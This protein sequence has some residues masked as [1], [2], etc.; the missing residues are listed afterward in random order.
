MKTANP[1]TRSFATILAACVLAATYGVAAAGASDHPLNGSGTAAGGTITAGST[2][3]TTPTGTAFS[4]QIT[5]TGNNGTVTFVTTSGSS[6]TVSSSGA[7]SAPSTLTPGT[8][9]V[10]GT[11][12][13]AFGNAGTWTFALS[14]TN[15]GIT[16]LAP[17]AG[18]LAQGIKGSF[19]IYAAD[20]DPYNE[21]VIRGLATGLTVSTTGVISTDGTTPVGTYVLSGTMTDTMGNTGTWSFTLSITNAGITQST[22]TAGS[23]LQ[24]TT[25]SFQLTTTDTNPVTYVASGTL[26]TGVTVSSSGTIATT[27]TTP[28]GTYK[29]SGTI[30]DTLGNTGTFTYTLTVYGPGHNKT[31]RIKITREWSNDLSVGRT[32][33]LTI[34][35]V[36]FYGHPRIVSHPALRTVVVSATHT[37]LRVKVSARGQLRGGVYTF[38]IIEPNGQRANLRCRLRAK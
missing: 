18:S 11:D 31:T 32:I 3:G 20:Q 4:G 8:Y 17:T 9:V 10:S 26:P 2:S 1:L 28:V 30:S 14:V 27:S 5:T 37:T 22:L 21:D 15:A 25:G 23:S 34:V 13:D 24:G 38:T 12:S 36:G 29:L 16:Q 33:I 35:G 19:Q 7:V 6:F